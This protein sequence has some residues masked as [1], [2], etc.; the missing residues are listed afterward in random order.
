MS[1]QS[2]SKMR[3]GQVLPKSRIKTRKNK[4]LEQLLSY[5]NGYGFK[6]PTPYT[7]IKHI[8]EEMKALKEVSA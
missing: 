7:A 2:V 5:K 4:K 6:D 1:Q 8:R 3:G